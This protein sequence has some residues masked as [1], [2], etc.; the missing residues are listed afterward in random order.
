ML[1]GLVTLLLFLLTPQQMVVVLVLKARLAL[2][3]KVAVRVVKK[4]TMAVAAQAVTLVKAA[5]VVT[6]LQALAALE[7]Q[8][9]KELRKTALL[10]DGFI[11][12]LEVA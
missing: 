12:A 2:L 4:A 6:A 3:A 11:G 8:V 1:A 9:A 5:V 10:V 7:A